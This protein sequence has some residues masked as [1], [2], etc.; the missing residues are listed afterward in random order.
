MA[1]NAI[2]QK[3][4][5]TCIVSKQGVNLHQTRQTQDVFNSTLCA[6]AHVCRQGCSAYQLAIT[7]DE[8]DC[9]GNVIQSHCHILLPAAIATECIS[10]TLCDQAA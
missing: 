7:V 3:V 2:T 10:S 1:I 6:F 8:A 9:L 4:A 5:W